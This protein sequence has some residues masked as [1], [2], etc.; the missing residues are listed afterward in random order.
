MKLLITGGA[1]FIGSN[2]VK[3]FIKDSRI[4][5]VRV[6][7]DLSNGFYENI[8]EFES[9]SKFEFIKGDIC[10]YN[11]CLSC[12]QGIDVI[13]HHA[14][15]GS[16]P[17]SIENPMRSTEVNIL[18]SVNILHSAV[19]NKINRIVLACSSSVYGDNLDIIKKENN[20]GNPL[21][22]YALT[23]FTMEQMAYV[24]YKTYGLNYIGLRYFN[25]F[26]P[27]QNPDN[28]YSAVI[29]RFCKSFLNNE[30]PIINGDGTTSRDFT[31]ID[32]IILANELAIF[33][34]NSN[35]INKIFNTACQESISLNDIVSFLNKISNKN[36]KVTYQQ[37]RKGDI[38]FSKANISEISHLLDY[39]PIVN[40]KDGLL[41]TYNWYSKNNINNN[42]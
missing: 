13:S 38:K 23:K 25:V 16:V 18:G 40:F 37:E 6:V 17:R 24:F 3:H 8:K 5:L 31:Y 19:L 39:K 7:D 30:S 11:T 2:L 36:I 15:L 42:V 35:A 9:N 27:R 12:V 33:T 4:S 14:A 26:G 1:G 21:S 29:P 22:P 20:I 10:D 28:Q 41:K 32:N 34:T